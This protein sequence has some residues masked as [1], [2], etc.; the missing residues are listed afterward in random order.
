MEL[1][2]SIFEAFFRNNNPKKGKF[3]H[4]QNEENDQT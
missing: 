2:P 1:N 3:P 4:H